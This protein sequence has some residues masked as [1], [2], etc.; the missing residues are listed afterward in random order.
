MNQYEWNIPSLRRRR[1]EAESAA[2]MSG[3][4]RRL[5][6]ILSVFVLSLTIFGV[7]YAMEVICDKLPVFL[8]VI[9][10]NYW[11]YLLFSVACFALTVVLLWLSAGP[12]SVGI[13]RTAV[14]MCR[15]E[16]TSLADIFAPFSSHRLYRRAVKIAWRLLLRFLPLIGCVYAIMLVWSE[17]YIPEYLVW[18]FWSGGIAIILGLAFL[19]LWMLSRVRGFVILATDDTALPLYE[20]EGRA[21]EVS[22]N[23][24]GW[25]LRYECRIVWKI[26]LSLLPLGVVFFLH[27][28]PFS[29]LS[30]VKQSMMAMEAES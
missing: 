2:T 4:G 1:L 14:R 17:V 23:N 19:G 5:T 25:L 11:L 26:A 8:P 10:R 20:A 21:L 9:E 13:L 18:L 29:I 28:A 7:I 24:R 15:A 16:P 27:T 22:R 3:D 12:L 6:L 30:L